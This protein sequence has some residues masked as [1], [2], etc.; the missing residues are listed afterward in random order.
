MSFKYDQCIGLT[1]KFDQQKL[2]VQGVLFYHHI[3][4]RNQKI[5]HIWYVKIKP[6]VKG[7]KSNF[8]LSEC[9]MYF[10][11]NFDL[12][13]VVEYISHFLFSIFFLSHL[14][15]NFITATIL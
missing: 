5:D 8:S 9:N 2:G 6:L 14:P 1:K 7:V 15:Y 12:F 13:G 11:K 10:I 3:Q 4:E